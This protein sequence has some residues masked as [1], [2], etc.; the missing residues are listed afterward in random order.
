MGLIFKIID[1]N[2][3]LKA[4]GNGVYVGS[5][6][7]LADGFIH[8]SAAHQIRETARR[9][10]AGQSGLVLV[11]FETNVFGPPLVWEASRGGDQFPHLYADFNPA[12]ATWVI[13]LPWDGS[14]H[15]FPEDIA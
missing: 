1:Q 3:W 9:H 5:A 6:I 12:H 13:D 2:D 8:F 7:D 10:Y 11:A 14:E 15:K 4:V